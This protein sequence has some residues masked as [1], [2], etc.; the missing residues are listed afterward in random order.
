[1]RKAISNATQAQSNHI[2]K[3]GE[4]VIVYNENLEFIDENWLLDVDSP[5]LD[6]S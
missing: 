5:M 3:I 6:I 1:M 4:L 2:Q